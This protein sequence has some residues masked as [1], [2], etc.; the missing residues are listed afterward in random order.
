MCGAFIALC[1]HEGGH[2]YSACSPVRSSTADH[3][4]LSSAAWNTGL[5]GRLLAPAAGAGATNTTARSSSSSDGSPLPS[6]STSRACTSARSPSR[7]TSTPSGRSAYAARLGHVVDVSRTGAARPR[8]G[9]P[10]R[11]VSDM[12]WT[13]PGQEQHALGPDA[14]ALPILHAPSGASPRA[15]GRPRGRRRKRPTRAPRQPT[16][17]RRTQTAQTDRTRPWQRPPSGDV[18]TG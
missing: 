5:R 9:A 7:S 18:V 4:H 16:R 8:A 10:M 17:R 15:E 11:H 6:A 1:G 2:E 12:S 13:C 14:P 3:P